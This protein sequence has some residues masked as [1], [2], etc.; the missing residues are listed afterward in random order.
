MK[1]R[2]SHKFFLS[3]AVAVCVVVGTT[4]C[5]HQ[6]AA[7]YQKS[8]FQPLAYVDGS[9]TFF[10]EEYVDAYMKFRQN[11]LESARQK[12]ERDHDS[13]A[14]TQDQYDEKIAAY[15]LSKGQITRDR[16]L[17]EIVQSSVVEQEASR[18]QLDLDKR[19][20]ES[21]KRA[22]EYTQNYQKILP[23]NLE[24]NPEEGSASF[25]AFLED[26]GMTYSEY[27]SSYL[28]YSFYIQALK[29][30]VK[31]D[32][33]AHKELR[34]ESETEQNDAFDAYL[35]HLSEKAQVTY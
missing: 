1:N 13:G 4:A 5:K 24:A 17:K 33:L 16:L 20:G 28:A 25:D 12:I 11:Y 10:D 22:Q 9:P 30:D 34:G 27:A 6:G 2:F 15:E 23:E 3:L 8:G 21:L 32:M 7:F 29:E 19:I 18:R 35:N 31:K 14:L 26:L